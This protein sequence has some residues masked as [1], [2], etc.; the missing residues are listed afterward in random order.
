MIHS[1]FSYGSAMF[2]YIQYAEQKQKITLTFWV[3]EHY[4]KDCLFL[5]WL[6]CNK[7]LK[8]EQNFVDILWINATIQVTSEMSLQFSMI[9]ELCDE[10]DEAW[11]AEQNV[12]KYILCVFQTM[13]TFE[14]LLQRSEGKLRPFILTR[15]HYAGSQRYAAVWTGDNAA[16]WGHLQFTIPMCLSLSVA[17]I[18][19]C[20]A[21]VGGFFKNPDAELFTRWYQVTTQR[22]IIV[23]TL[24]LLYNKVLFSSLL[25]ALCSCASKLYFLFQNVCARVRACVHFHTI[26]RPFQFV[27]LHK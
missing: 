1:A 3:K 26:V 25:H 12:N 8:L 20:G 11:L 10:S 2:V 27:G 15:S 9:L 17:G 6:S 18:S 21:D 23:W 7:F 5:F 19:F 4:S 13:S 22:L 16:E 14:G 24:D